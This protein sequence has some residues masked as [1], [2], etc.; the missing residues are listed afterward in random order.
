MRFKRTVVSRRWTPP[1]ASLAMFAVLCATLVYWALQLFEP[2]VPIAPAGSLADQRDAPDLGAAARLFGQP[3][4]DRTAGLATAASNIQVL[5]VAASARHGSAVLAVDGKQP[6]AYQIGDAVTADAKLV[7]VRSDAAIIERN[8]MR[9]EL[10]A[11]QRPSVATLSSG[12]TRSGASTAASAPPVSAVPA[13][14]PAG[15]PT[16]PD[17]QPPNVNVRTPA[18]PAVAGTAPAQPAA[19]APQADTPAAEAGAAAGDGQAAGRP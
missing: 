1:V 3:V 4:G 14:T 19:P 5:G 13:P 8:G 7:E 18:P 9:I 15:G 11:P 2:A 6:K 16:A 17:A 10:P 12:P